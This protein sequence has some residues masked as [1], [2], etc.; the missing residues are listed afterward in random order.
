M[1]VAGQ[2]HIDARDTRPAI[3]LSTSK[4]LCDNTTT[5]FGTH[6]ARTSSTIS[7]M[8]SSRIPKAVF[9]EH[10]ARVCDGHIGESLT[11]NG[12]LGAATFKHFIGFEQFG[13]FIPFGVKNVLTQCRKGRFSTILARALEPKREFPVECHRIGFNAFMVLTMS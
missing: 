10:P 7:C 9:W 8:R 2:D 6:A 12:D 4:P 1:G 11:D 5:D 3:F 13:W